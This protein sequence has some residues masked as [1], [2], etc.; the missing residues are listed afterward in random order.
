MSHHNPLLQLASDRIDDSWSP[1]ERLSDRELVTSVMEVLADPP[2]GP[3]DSFVLH[4]PLELMARAELLAEV[5]PSERAQ[6]RRRIVEIATAWNSYEP[7]AGEPALAATV[8]LPTAIAAGDLDAADDAVVDL[9]E[10]ASVD[11]FIGV[12]AGSLLAH[13]G[14]AGHLAIFLDHLSRSPR[15]P[16]SALSMSRA[17]VRDIAAHPDWTLQWIDRPASTAHRP[18]RDFIDVLTNPPSAGDLE[19]NFIYPTMHLA[20]ESGLASELLARP[21]ADLTLEEARRQI[22]RIA[23]MSMLQDDPS[24]APYGWTHC[25]TMPQ[26]T[27]AVATRM[28]DTR[29][30]VAIAATYVLGFRATQSVRAVDLDWQPPRPRAT[31]DL[32]QTDAEGAVSLAWHS[33][34]PGDV[35]RRL[36]TFAATHHDAHLAKY[37]LACLHAAHHDPDA[38]PL[39]RAAAARLAVWWRDSDD[40]EAS[41]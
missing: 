19:S 18:A 26:A 31:G 21:V 3:A 7:H 6:V 38:A 36:A 16:R 23:A 1:V 41:R 32:L 22:L 40:A 8:S 10:H 2:T 9:A 20:D 37:T 14:G 30:A 11:R 28:A 24:N 17:L 13:L 4:A 27:L 29:R 39:Y 25:L 5:E 34:D 15:A 12:A 35:A 33:D